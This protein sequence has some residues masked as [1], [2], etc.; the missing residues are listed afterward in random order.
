MAQYVS[1]E[2]ALAE[3][4]RGASTLR[5]LVS[6]RKV[7]TKAV[8]KANP[9]RGSGFDRVYLLSDLKKWRERNE[10]RYDRKA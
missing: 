1:Q 5:E 10:G 6:L 4:K 8:P 9:G 2:Q 7:R 3:I